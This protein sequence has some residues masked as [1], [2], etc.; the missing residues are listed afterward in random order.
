M[1]ALLIVLAALVSQQASANF[2]ESVEEGQ[3]VSLSVLS[4]RTYAG[5]D[6]KLVD[7]NLIVSEWM[8]ATKNFLLNE[9][10][11]ENHQGTEFTRVTLGKTEEPAQTAYDIYLFGKPKKGEVQV[12]GGA[13]GRI[14]YKVQQTQ[15][16]ETSKP[17]PIGF[18]PMMSIACKVAS[19]SGY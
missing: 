6:I 19:P 11:V 9:A 2:P 13:I 5:A 12:L 3:R 8:G 7:A 15:K 14:G 17:L 1:K 10:A 18:Y 16:V 4:C